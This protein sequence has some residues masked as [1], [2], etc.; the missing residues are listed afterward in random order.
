MFL[1]LVFVLAIGAP[2]LLLANP[3]LDFM[4]N[5]TSTKK[6][7]SNGFLSNLHMDSTLE[8]VQRVAKD[9]NAKREEALDLALGLGYKINNK[10][11]LNIRTFVSKPNTGSQ[12]TEISNTQLGLGIRGY[13]LSPRLSTV[14]SVSAILPTSVQSRE[15]DRL[16]GGISLSNGLRHQNSIL[17]V[18]Y[19]LGINENFHEFNVNALGSPNVQRTLTNTLITQFPLPKRFSVSAIG[20][21]N[22]GRTYAGKERSSF[23]FHGDLNYEMSDKMTLNIGL[24]NAGQALKANGVDSNISAYDADASVLRAGI[25][26]VL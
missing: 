2:T 26:I 1:Q 8:F 6:K 9:E 4:T 22:S 14:H 11:R 25:S 24:S 5:Q 21:Y 17:T 10:L 15:Q 3:N 19:L 13:E 23:Q 12:E 16:L 7:E 18:Q 20:V